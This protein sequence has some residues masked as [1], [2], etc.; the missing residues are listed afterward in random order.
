MTPAELKLFVAEGIL[1]SALGIFDD[2][3]GD[4][5]EDLVEH[6][7]AVNDFKSCVDSVIAVFEWGPESTSGYGDVIDDYAMGVYGP[8]T[9]DIGTP[10][11]QH[12]GST[13]PDVV[14]IIPLNL[15][16]GLRGQSYNVLL[17]P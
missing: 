10:D 3:L 1:T 15:S 6:Y 13:F 17:Y 16:N 2:C 14:G 12:S 4:V 11:V 8:Q 9:F 5:P 7:E